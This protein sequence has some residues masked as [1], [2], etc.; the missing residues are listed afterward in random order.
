MPPD[1]TPKTKETL[2]KRARYQCSNPDC[3]AH[4]V[5]PNTNPSKSTSIG[6]AAHI[7]GAKPEAARHDKEMSD[8][9]RSDITNGIWLCRNCHG[10]IDRDEARFPAELLL[11][12]RHEHEDR[13]LREMGSRGEILRKEMETRHLHFL[14]D[15]PQ[16]IQRV[17]IDQP[18]GWEWRLT[19]ELLRYLNRHDLRRLHDLQNGMYFRRFN[20]IHDHNFMSWITER[21]HVMANLVRPLS[22]LFE[23]LNTSWGEPGAHGDIEEIHHTC[24]LVRDLLKGMV[25][26]EEE[27]KFTQLPEEGEELRAILE[28][29][30]GRNLTSIAEIPLGLDRVVAMIGT[31][32]DGTDVS[33][34]IIRHKLSFNLP[35]DMNDRFG[36]A[37]EQYQKKM[38]AQH[39]H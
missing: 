15:Y 5:G 35:D 37:L 8:T 6:E 4:T 30:I 33:P 23:R 36:R 39:P 29:A 14:Q 38:N 10:L 28:D 18:E 17:A 13:V 16:I 12:W 24:L 19:A 34:L 1:F 25:D 31:D 20:R 11:L 2:A 21:T 26:H 7:F 9:T 3:R 27:L 32:H 22:R